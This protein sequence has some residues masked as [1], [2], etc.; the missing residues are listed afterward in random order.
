MNK[1]EILNQ[2][3][4]KS[5]VLLNNI[6]NCLNNINYKIDEL[7]KFKN[8][9]ENIIQKFEI[10]CFNYNIVD[11]MVESKEEF[12]KKIEQIILEI[13]SLDIINDSYS[14]DFNINKIKNINDVLKNTEVQLKNIE[15]EDFSTVEKLQMNAIKK[16]IY[17]KFMLEKSEID[18]AKFK[19]KF[20]KI[21]NRGAIAKAIDVFF[22]RE[23]IVD[24]KK[25]NMF[26]A[27]K[28]IDEAR[29][30]IDETEEPKKEYKIIEILAEVEIF[31]REN[32]NGR[33]R[34]KLSKIYKIRDN[35]YN[36]F[37][38]D[39]KELKNE[40]IEKQKSRLPVKINKRIIGVR[41]EREKI[42]TFLNQNGYVLKDENV[43][44]NSNLQNI[45]EKINSISNLINT[46]TKMNFKNIN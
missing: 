21:Q 10:K 41:K 5:K 13:K 11:K 6:S 37:S 29:N 14:L 23:D 24:M 36:I 30:N 15:K 33:N 16:G 39:S 38:I 26:F 34:R 12:S 46:E 44:F 9:Q 45:I 25:E 1:I 32:Y 17:D 18:R 3:K 2:E 42:I 43:T 35:I 28:E 31:L 40:I 4:L 8:Q 20:G 27:I 22:E 7:L 19:K